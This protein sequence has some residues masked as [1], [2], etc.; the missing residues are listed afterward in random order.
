MCGIAGAIWWDESDRLERST[1][2]RMMHVIRHR[3]PNGQGEFYQSID[4]QHPVGI[5]LGHR[6]LAIIDL[7]GGVQ[8]IGNEDGYVQVLLNGEIYNYR[9]LRTTL[10]SR[11]HIL[12]TQSDSEVVAHLYEDFGIDCLSY[13]NGMFA[14]AIWDSRKQQLILARDRLGKK[15]LWHRRD[16]NRLTF[17][18]ELKGLL[19]VPGAPRDIDPFALDEYLTL[20][21]VPARRSILSGYHKL[22]PGHYLRVSQGDI[23]IQRYWSV[24][25]PVSHD[26]RQASSAA[27]ELRA[28]VPDAVQLRM[29]S[30]V[31]LGAFLSGGVDSSLIVALM[32]EASQERIK[33]FSIGF[34]EPNFDERPFARLVAEQLG[35]D[36]HEFVVGPDVVRDLAEIVAHYDEP[37][38][39]SSAVPTWHLARATRQ[40]VTVALTGDGGDELFG[41]Y[42]RYRAARWM[43]WLDRLPTMGKGLLATWLPTIARLTPHG[44]RLHNRV[45]RLMQSTDMNP[46]QRY[47]EWVGIWRCRERTTLYTDRFASE[48]RD[49]QGGRAVLEAWTR[50]RTEDAVATAAYTDLCTY[51]PDDLLTKVDIASMAHGLECRQPLLDFRVVEAAMQLPSRWKTS[52]WRGKR[53]LRQLFEER[54]PKAIWNRPKK[55]FGI[56]VHDWFRGPLREMSHDLLVAPGARIESYVNQSAVESLWR[57]H[58]SHHRNGGYQLWSLLVLEHWLRHWESEPAPARESS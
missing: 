18:S 9:A 25:V 57:D 33:T 5:A 53:I 58:Q 13:L 14:L 56:P 45:T 12:R 6:R 30:D 15:P 31:P 27:Q 35:T 32:Q 43:S 36:H 19:Q 3:G 46:E 40:H 4:A 24:P 23:H 37:F 54:L 47:L 55:G 51:L 29:Q 44:E 38:G 52:A 16:G 22:A 26:T 41:G 7:V 10:Q 17:A 21:Y 48:L 2:A 42:D 39:D 20:Q 28:L 50:G 1:L 49:A 34:S 11:G 8:P